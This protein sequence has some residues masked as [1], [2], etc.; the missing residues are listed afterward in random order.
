MPRHTSLE[1]LF[2]EITQPDSAAADNPLAA[3]GAADWRALL[4]D[5]PM[6]SAAFAARFERSWDACIAMISD[7]FTRHPDDSG[8]QEI[9]GYLGVLLLT[10]QSLR[11]SERYRS[12]GD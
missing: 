3:W 4:L 6:D 12:V 9:Y 1:A 5:L 8:W 7:W 11:H 10:L 2:T